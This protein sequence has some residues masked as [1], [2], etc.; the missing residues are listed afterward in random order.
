MAISRA[1]CDLRIM[2]RHGLLPR[3]TH[4]LFQAQTFEPQLDFERHRRIDLEL[5]FEWSA[6][7]EQKLAQ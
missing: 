5:V 4:K 7:N 1:P 3:F 6:E 2:A